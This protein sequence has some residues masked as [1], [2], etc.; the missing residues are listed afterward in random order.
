MLALYDRGGGD[1][2]RSLFATIPF[3]G[4]HTRLHHRGRNLARSHLR[5]SERAMSA[6][7]CQS[8][9][10]CRKALQDRTSNATL[11]LSLKLL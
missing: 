2:K 5:A 10:L 1:V 7:H 8:A 3:T 4:F 6:R 9:E 11:L